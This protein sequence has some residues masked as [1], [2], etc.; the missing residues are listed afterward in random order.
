MPTGKINTSTTDT[1]EL[2]GEL[3]AMVK[4]ILII[5]GA[6]GAILGIRS[7]WSALGKAKRA[8]AVNEIRTTPSQN[9]TPIS[10]DIGGIAS[11]IY[12]CFYDY[13]GGMAEDEEGAIAALS[14]CPKAVMPDLKSAY[15]I[16]SDGEDLK[17]DF[18]KYCPD[19]YPTVASLLA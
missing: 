19:E 4:I 1:K 15:K 16:I 5:V 18:I 7:G 11:T 8:K 6:I 17:S 3:P 12:D 10:V 9:G 13:Y 2:W 14:G